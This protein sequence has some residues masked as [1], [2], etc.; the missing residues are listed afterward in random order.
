MVDILLIQPPIRDFYLTAKRTIPHG[1]SSIAASLEKAGFTVEILDG[2]ATAKSKIIDLPESMT[3]LRDFY[4][5]PDLSPF[6]LFHHYRHFGYSFEH[7]RAKAKI[8]GAF[9]IGISSLFT[10]YGE[11]ALATAR[12]VK[13]VCP[14]A[15][16]VMGGHH[17]SARPESVMACDALDYVLRGEGEVAL[18]ILAR[19]I[20]DC[21]SVE[22]VP[23]IV[24]R[25]IDET[26]H[27]SPPAVMENLDDYSP[28]ALHLVKNEY[29]K[30]AAGG[31]SVIMTSRGC[32]MR[33]TYC[34]MGDSS[35]LPYRQRSYDSVLAEIE[36]AVDQFGAR[37][38]D[39]EDEHLTLKREPFMRFLEQFII[40][41]Q[42]YDIELRAM[43]GLYPPSLDPE[44][45]GLMK[46]AGFKALNLSLCS[47][48]PEQLQ[49]FNRPDVSRAFDRVLNA[50]ADLNLETVGYIIVGAPDQDPLSSVEDLLYLS[51]RSVLAGVSVFYPAPGSSDFDVCQRRGLLPES[52]SLMRSSTLPLSGKTTRR[53]SVTLLRLGRILNFMKALDSQSNDRLG[54]NYRMK[55]GQERVTQGVRLLKMFFEDGLIRGVSP[56]GEIFDHSVSQ[57]LIA[58]FLE[59]LKKETKDKLLRGY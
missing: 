11:M 18:P 53:D 3:D 25:K 19:A 36:V 15:V 31:T 52:E 50:A 6:S 28:P 32:P 39:F 24:F 43:N 37:F 13:E 58:A 48:V 21:T 8:S 30:R 51:Q 34:S 35:T 46:K 2:L 14:G 33:C 38:I 4:R 49:R 47:I 55:M 10:A 12:L 1:L 5:G 9:L 27:I 54:D 41:F 23:G 16:V 29:Y 44:M 57:N 42:G 40:R 26:L 45:M 22:N 56:D 20:Q 59:G 17:P 7:I